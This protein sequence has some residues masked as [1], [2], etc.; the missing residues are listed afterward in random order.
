MQRR[1]MIVLALVVSALAAVSA[2]DQWPKF[3][4]PDAGVVPDDPLLPDRWSETETVVWKAEIPGLS[5]SSPVVWDDHVI[6]TTAISS[7]KEAAPE[8]GLYDPGDDHGKTRS[9][10]INRWMVY[11]LDFQTGEI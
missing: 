8:K 4:G 10:S 5:W 1:W 11:D 2:A 3:R 7:G 6:V 9:T